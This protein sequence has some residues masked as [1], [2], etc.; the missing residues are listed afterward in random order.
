MIR[1]DKEYAAVHFCGNR[2][3]KRTIVPGRPETG[4]ING[5]RIF[6]PMRFCE[7]K[8]KDVINRCNCKKLG[9]VCD[10]ILDECKG[11]ITALVV[12]GPFRLC[13]ILGPDQ[14]YIIPWCRICQIGPDIILVEVCEEEV[15]CSRKRSCSRFS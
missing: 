15:L 11:C 3:L 8:E 12:P 13:G 2:A 1:K 7:L 9:K 14:E 5:G 10:L 4:Q 6:T